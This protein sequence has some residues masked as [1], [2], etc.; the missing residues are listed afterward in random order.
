VNC[1][2]SMVFWGA[3]SFQKNLCTH[4]GEK[5]E[6]SLDMR[7]STLYLWFA[8]LPSTQVSCPKS[9][10]VNACAEDPATLG[11]NFVVL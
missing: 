4:R 3:V 7:P 2:F 1:A 9:R 5:K 10:Q 11:L 8:V 6:I